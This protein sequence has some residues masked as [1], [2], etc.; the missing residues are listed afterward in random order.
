VIDFLALLKQDTWRLRLRLMFREIGS[1]LFARICASGID[2]WLLNVQHL[3]KF[4]NVRFLLP[5]EWRFVGDDDRR[6]SNVRHT[7]DFFDGGY[8]LPTLWQTFDPHLVTLL[9][10]RD[11]AAFFREWMVSIIYYC[12]I[13]TVGTL[14]GTHDLCQ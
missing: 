3:D 9:Y 13:S 10:A 8:P 7:N 1:Q 12:Y 2:H 14:L 11:Q 4:F 6:S 5:I